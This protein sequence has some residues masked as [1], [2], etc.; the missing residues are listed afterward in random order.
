M[1]TGRNGG[2]V[3]VTNGGGVVWGSD[4]LSVGRLVFVRVGRGVL[5]VAWAREER[6]A[7]TWRALAAAAAALATG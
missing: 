4:G 5:E 3:T 6:L 1:L 7:A 2:V